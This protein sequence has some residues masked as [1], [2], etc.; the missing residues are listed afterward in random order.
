MPVAFIQ[1]LHSHEIAAAYRERRTDDRRPDAVGLAGAVVNGN[2]NGRAPVIIDKATLV[3]LGLVFSMV[4]TALSAFTWANAQLSKLD[5]RLVA[6]DA[7]IEAARV[8]R[9]AMSNLFA[10]G[11]S[12]RWTEIDMK[13]WAERLRRSNG[14]LDVPEP[15][16]SELP[17]ESTILRRNK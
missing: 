1:L 10:L 3:P 6:I 4:L 2:G 14:E 17:G 16:H 5:A 11:L 12:S 7:K 8:E 13:L 9:E 15:E